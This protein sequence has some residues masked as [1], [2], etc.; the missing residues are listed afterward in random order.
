MLFDISLFA[1][2]CKSFLAGKRVLERFQHDDQQTAELAR[3]LEHI[4]VIMLY[5]QC[6][7]PKDVHS[8]WGFFQ[9]ER[10][11][12]ALGSTPQYIL[13]PCKAAQLGSVASCPSWYA[14]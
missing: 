11:L 12:Y 13:A 6:D 1:A 8:N 10:C 3:G 9:R 5:D 7:A 2:I 4:L 14:S